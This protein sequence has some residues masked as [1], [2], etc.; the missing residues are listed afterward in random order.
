MQTA[1]LPDAR[2]SEDCQLGWSNRQFG[3]VQGWLLGTSI[4]NCDSLA[5]TCSE[6]MAGWRWVGAARGPPQASGRLA[7]GRLHR[8]LRA[9]LADQ[10]MAAPAWVTQLP[11]LTLWPG[12]IVGLDNL[13]RHQGVAERQAIGNAGAHLLL[14]SPDPNPIEVVLARL[15]TLVRGADNQWI[16]TIRHR[17]GSLL[18]QFI[19]TRCANRVSHAGQPNST[20]L[21][22]D[23]GAP[24][25]R[26]GWRRQRAEH[27]AAK[28]ASPRP[29]LVGTPAAANMLIGN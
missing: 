22:S 25:C 14:Y 13:D 24:G 7:L 23:P 21:C 11:I 18:Q 15:K 19:P 6:S 20:L 4:A 10:W 1:Q 29:P 2:L 3:L 16:A 5:V 12:G 8:I 9:Q 28:L 26:T 27:D 17:T